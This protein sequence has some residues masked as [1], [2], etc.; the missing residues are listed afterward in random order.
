M[1][2]PVAVAATFQVEPTPAH[3][4]L[5]LRLLGPMEVLCHGRP[6]PPLRTHK[7]LWLIALLTLRQGA[8]VDRAWLATTLWSG[9]FPLQ[10]QYNL[11][12]CLSDLRTALGTEAHRIETPSAR[13]IRLD[14][15]DADVDI[16]SL[17]SAVRAPVARQ[18]LEDAAALYRGELLEGCA[19]KWV[20][21]DRVRY[22]ELYLGALETLAEMADA[23]G[24]TS[25]KV[26]HLRRAVSA[27]PEREHTQRTLMEALADLG[28][29]AAVTQTYRSLRVYLR[30]KMNLEPSRETRTLY[31]T[32]TDRLAEES[33]RPAVVA[34][35]LPRPSDLAAAVPEPSSGA[36][37]PGSSYYIERAADRHILQAIRRGDG[38]ILV[39]GPRQIG[40]T[41]LIA[42]TVARLRSEERRV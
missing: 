7:G 28:D 42:Q 35:P 21:A 26:A 39:K 11:R 24:D 31:Q 6:L 37:L 25:R 15:S 9:S 19:E 34:A 32:L 1:L 41:S 23:A 2:L 4:P 13:T 5:T 12:R 22:A 16:K 29:A 18:V 40:K 30:D 3:T 33:A 14:L 17:E 8:P 20:E 27:Q 36:I 38:L 10:A